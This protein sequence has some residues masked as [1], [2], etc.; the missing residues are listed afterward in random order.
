MPERLLVHK[1]S[2]LRMSLE[3]RVEFR[4]VSE[5]YVSRHNG[6]LLKPLGTI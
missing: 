5:A 2:I 4:T 3:A 6:A 1:F